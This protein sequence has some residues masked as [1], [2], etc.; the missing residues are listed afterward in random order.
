MKSLLFLCLLF[1]SL[2]GQSAIAQD[3]TKV[4]PEPKRFEAS[5]TGTFNN[6]K[7]N[8]KS[9]VEETFLRNSKGEVAASLWSTAYLKDG[10]EPSSR[11]VTFIFNGGPGSASIWLH[12]GFFGP[13]VVKVDSEA[14]EDDGAAPYRV[15]DNTSAL[16]DITDLVF[17]DPIG[18]GYSQVLGAGKNEDYWG[19]VEDANSIAQFIRIWISKNQRWQAPKFLAGESFGTTRAAKVAEVLEGDGQHVALNGIIL[20]S[21]ALDYQGSSSWEDNLTSF[22]TYIPAMAVTARYH[23]KAGQGK[24]ISEFAAEARDF[25]YTTYLPYLY[26]GAKN[27]PEKDEEIAEKL[28]YFTGL[29]KAYILRSDN[30]IQMHRFKKELLREEGKAIGTLDGRFSSE[31]TDKASEGPV[32]GDPSDYMTE[33]AYTAAFN[34]YLDVGLKVKMDRPY[35]ASNSQIGGAWRWRPVPDGRY[36]EPSFVST[37]RAL[38]EVMHRNPKMKVMVANGYYDLITPFFDAEFTFARYDFPQD[39]IQMYYYEAGHMMYNRQEDFDSLAQDIRGF[40][41]GVLKR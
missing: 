41:N 11:P 35:L 13:K 18:T 36:W 1:S 37:A 4:I 34:H 28:A 17:V 8:Y 20:I 15:V 32:L 2:F 30:Q 3:S 7:I 9:V 26:L 39:R 6:Q 5:H 33:G 12:M 21:Q 23:G 14:Q 16:L 19:L 27:S 38:S 40:M 24:S 29:N 31:E 10:A 25:A 22:F